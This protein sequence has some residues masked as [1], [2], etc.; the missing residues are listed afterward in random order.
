MNW[1]VNRS[2]IEVPNGSVLSSLSDVSVVVFLYSIESVDF[3]FLCKKNQK[4]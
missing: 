4:G 2:Q 3:C 1:H